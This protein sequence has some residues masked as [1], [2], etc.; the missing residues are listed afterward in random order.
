LASLRA[1]LEPLP[2]ARLASLLGKL[3]RNPCRHKKA[4][5]ALLRGQ[6]LLGRSRARVCRRVAVNSSAA[7]AYSS[8]PDRPRRRR[9]EL[10][11]WIGLRCHRI[12]APPRRIGL[13]SS[14]SRRQGE[15]PSREPNGFDDCLASGL[16]EVR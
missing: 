4:D 16:G 13:H 1:C 2:I 5:L 6:G 7:A 9:F 8:S 12:G 14:C 3:A 10:H 15:R 11:H